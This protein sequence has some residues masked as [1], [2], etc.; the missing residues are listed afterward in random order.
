M[1]HMVRASYS[2]S[3]ELDYTRLH[4]YRVLYPPDCDIHETFSIEKNIALSDGT[5]FVGFPSSSGRRCEPPIFET[6]AAA[7]LAATPENPSVLVGGDDG[8]RRAPVPVAVVGAAE[9][10][11]LGRVLSSDRVLLHKTPVGKIFQV[12]SGKYIEEQFSRSD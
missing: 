8:G 3:G 12:S 11:Q 6:A 4:E 1:L 10:L 2:E 9:P 5:T 7:V